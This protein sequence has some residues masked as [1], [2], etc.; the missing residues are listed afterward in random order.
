MQESRDHS[1]MEFTAGMRVGPDGRYEIVRI[2]GRGGMGIVYEAVDHGLDEPRQVAIKQLPK[3]MAAVPRSV[4]NVKREVRIAQSLGHPNIVQ[5]YE[6]LEWRDEHLVVMEWIDGPTLAYQLIKEENRR[7]DPDKSLGYMK[8]IAQALDYSHNR[9]PPVVHRD[10]KPANIMVDSRGEIKVTD[11]GLSKEVKASVARVSTKDSSGSLEYMPYEQYMGAKPHPI[12]DVYALGICAYEFLNGEPPFTEGDLGLQHKERSPDP[13]E[14]VSEPAMEAILKALAKDPGE[15]YGTAGEFVKAFEAVLKGKA[16]EKAED[17]ARRREAEPKPVKKKSRAGLYAVIAA[18]ALVAVVA[19]GF[20]V[21]SNMEE[22]R[23]QERIEAQARLAEEKRK[24][25]EA[26]AKLAA[27]E[28]KAEEE[29]K[30]RETAQAEAERKARATEQAKMETSGDFIKMVRIRAGTF[31]MGSPSDESGR[32]EDEGP[33]HHVTISRDFYMGVTEVTQGQWRE[34][35]GATPSRFSNCG[36]DC[37]MENV[38]RFDA[39]KFCNKLSEREG[40]TPAYRISREIVTWDK[41]ADGYRLP[42]EA[43]WEYACRAGTTTPFYTGRCLS[44]DE[45][46]YDGNY[47]KDGCPKGQYRKKTVKVGS[48]KANSWGLYDMHGNVLEWCWD[49]KADYP[50]GSVTDPAGPSSGSGRVVR[51]GSWRSD[52]RYCRSAGRSNVGPGVRGSIVGLR[53]LRPINP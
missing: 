53:L 13:I 39:V 16:A 36:D 15:R 41:S 24:A 35:M 31:K 45:A 37:P 7:F 51:G 14:G 4:E 22:G 11:F 27:A 29:K 1:L 38:L 34:V 12:Q 3:L 43:E 32:D 49:W 33:V 52:A 26:R 28:K 25:E 18:L 8:S 10:L 19:A 46:N 2:C 20:I 17:V 48:F 23:R 47:T 6:Y 9:K 40:L 30:R 21:Y 50:S 44:T 5:V 42:T